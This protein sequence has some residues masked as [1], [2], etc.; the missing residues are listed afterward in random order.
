MDVKILSG[1][2][3]S[4]PYEETEPLKP[5]EG[6]DVSHPLHGL[7]GKT[8]FVYIAYFLF[9]LWAPVGGR[10]HVG[11]T[12]VTFLGHESGAGKC[13]CHPF[14]SIGVLS[15]WNQTLSRQVFIPMGLQAVYSKMHAQLR[16]DKIGVESED[17][18]RRV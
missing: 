16:R 7:F 3:K 12:I 2:K 13:L 15:G 9:A 5:D 4:P 14:F 1:F 17:Y 11:Q 8:E 10:R 18:K 6:R